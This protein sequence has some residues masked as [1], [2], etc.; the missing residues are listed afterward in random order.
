[1]V[2]RVYSLESNRIGMRIYSDPEHL[3]QM[4]ELVFKGHTWC[5]TPGDGTVPV[6]V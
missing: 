3:R 1:M 4:G 2:F 5:I 6:E